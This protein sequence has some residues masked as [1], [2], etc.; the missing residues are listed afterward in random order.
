MIIQ[1]LQFVKSQSSLAELG[2]EAKFSVCGIPVILQFLK[3][4]AVVPGSSPQI[5]S[6]QDKWNQEGLVSHEQARWSPGNEPLSEQPTANKE[7]CRELISPW[8]KSAKLSAV[9]ES[10]VVRLSQN[11]QIWEDS[12]CLGLEFPS[13]LIRELFWTRYFLRLVI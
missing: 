11:K 5:S 8:G 1:W 6:G 7:H 3:Q 4:K 2:L 12:G 13:S 9:L 10:P